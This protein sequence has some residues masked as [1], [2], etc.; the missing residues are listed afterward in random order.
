VVGG[1]ILVGGTL[2]LA[3]GVTLGW[4]ALHR[5]GNARITGKVARDFSTM[6]MFGFFAAG[7]LIAAVI[8]AVAT[9]LA[10]G[11]EIA[12]RNAPICAAGA[13]GSCRSQVDAVVDRTW[14]DS[15]KGPN[16]IEVTVGGHREKIEIDTAT[17]VWQKLIPGQTLELTSWKGKVTQVTRLG[18]GTMQTSDSPGFTLLISAVFLGASLFGLIVFSAFGLVYWLSWQT[19]RQSGPLLMTAGGDWA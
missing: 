11:D 7:C 17:N 2:G 6:A 1:S 13:N 4:R 10:L 14:A 15:S 18:V 9:I 3:A 12:Y 19:G 8:C 5:G 16:W